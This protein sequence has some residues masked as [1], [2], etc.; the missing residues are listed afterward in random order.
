[1]SEHEMKLTGWQAIVAIVVLIGVLGLRLATLD[2]KKSDAALM[3]EIN[4]KLLTD[5]FP[6][7]VARLKE[8]VEGGNGEQVA[9]VAESVTSTRVD[10]ESVRV[11]SPLFGFS[12]L[13]DVV[14]KVTYSL[15]DASGTREKGTVYYLFRHGLIGNT[16]RYKSK[17]GVVQYYLNFM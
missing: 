1:M 11:S 14:V 6:N 5:Y 12:N 16:W 4:Q 13:K 15:N 7:D 3:R 9:S 2:D 8:A 10:I 17:S